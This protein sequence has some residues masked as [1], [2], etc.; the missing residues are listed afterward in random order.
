[1]FPIMYHRQTCM[2]IKWR[3]MSRQFFSSVVIWDSADSGCRSSTT[4]F[5]ESA[6]WTGLSRTRWHWRRD[7]NVPLHHFYFFWLQPWGWN[8]SDEAALGDGN[9]SV[10]QTCWLLDTPPSPLCILKSTHRCRDVSEFSMFEH[11]LLNF[12]ILVE[13]CI[14]FLIILM[15]SHVTNFTFSVRCSEQKLGRSFMNKFGHILRNLSERK[16]QLFPLRYTLEQL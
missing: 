8:G 5:A 4:V 7:F 10:N 6:C 9:G 1:M 16:I 11:F 14:F 15:N 12:N 2:W 13:R 3:Q